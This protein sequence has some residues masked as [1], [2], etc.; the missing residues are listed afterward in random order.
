MYGGIEGQGKIGQLLV[1]LLLQ[2][3]LLSCELRVERRGRFIRP[4]RGD[5]LLCRICTVLVRTQYKCTYDFYNLSDFTY[6]LNALIFT[7][8]TGKAQYKQYMIMI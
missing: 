1:P 5:L 2:S 7:F 4:K 3:F 6:Y 8:K